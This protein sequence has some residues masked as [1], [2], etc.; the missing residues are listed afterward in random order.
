MLRFTRQ[1]NPYRRLSACA[2]GPSGRDIDCRIHI[3]VGI[4]STGCASEDRLA[5][6]VS[7]CAMP[8]DATGLRCVRRV[9][10]LDSPWRLVLQA[11]DEQSPA[12][13]QDASV[14]PSLGAATIGQVPTGLLGIGFGLRSPDHRGD[15]QIFN[16]D[17]IEASSE[18]SAGFFDPVLAS[19]GRAGVQF[20]DRVLRSAAPLGAAL[21]PGK[22]TLQLLQPFLFSFRQAGAD[23]EFPSGQ[24]SRHCDAAVHADGVT[25]AG[26]G[27]RCR[28]HGQGK[29]PTTYAIAG[30][31]VRL[32]AGY[33]AGQPELYPADLGHVDL[34]PFPV[35]LDDAG[36]LAPDNTEAFVQSGLPPARPSVGS[37][38]EVL[39]SLVEVAQRLL[40][41]GLRPRAKPLE[42]S[43]CFGQLAALFREGRC[44]ALVSRPHRP[45][46]KG[47]V[48]YIPGMAA[49]LQQRRLLRR[50]RVQ[51]EPGHAI[52]PIRLHRQSTTSEGRESRLL[53]GR[54]DGASP[55]QLK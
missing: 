35:Q 2:D 49:Q 9:Y 42:R 24:G 39:D 15:P 31:A 20:G 51:P 52:Y 50:C 36:C 25:C 44:R 45:L 40:L 38:A 3:G 55:R 4:V 46:F 48:P 27:D 43:P 54:S 11:P 22:T 29:V 19:V 18:I 23:Q 37:T 8:A 12:A 5:L 34:G 6:T 33:R 30:D 1:R 14:Q 28:N 16:P 26:P 17:Q 21:T 13:S 41:H 53:A 47:E 7:R 10:F 32:R